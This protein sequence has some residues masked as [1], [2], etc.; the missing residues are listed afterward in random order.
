MIYR[1]FFFFF[2]NYYHAPCSFLSFF[3]KISTAGGSGIGICIRGGVGEGA[4]D[5][6]G[7]IGSRVGRDVGTN[8]TPV[9]KSL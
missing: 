6:A 7:A 1:I 5:N 8:S 2:K 3:K 4:V 9:N